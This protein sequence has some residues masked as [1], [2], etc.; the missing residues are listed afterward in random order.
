[1][2]AV[3]AVGMILKMSSRRG[4][5]DVTTV[6]ISPS[7]ALREGER[8]KPLLLDERERRELL[9]SLRT[10]P[11][12]VPL[13]DHLIDE[14]IAA[15]NDDEIL[16]TKTA[17][18]FYREFM[19]IGDNRS[20]KME[21]RDTRQK[22]RIEEG[23]NY[24]DVVIERLTY[25][26]CVVS[27]GDAT[28]SLPLSPWIEGF[29]IDK[30]L[31]GGPLGEDEIARRANYYNEKIRPTFEAASAR[32]TPG[33]HETM[34]MPQSAEQIATNVAA[35]MEHVAPTFIEMS[36]NYTPKPGERIPR[37]PLSEE[38]LELNKMSYMATH[39]PEVMPTYPAWDKYF[40]DTE[41][42]EKKYGS[43]PTP[44]PSRD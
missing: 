40:K 18:W 32:Y 37:K 38:D 5:F 30:I 19:E 35:Y 1:V 36:K 22:W 23:E 44:I 43:V 20:G 31:G 11:T 28:R 7:I 27:L 42:Y 2:I 34:P 33:P 39:H 21:N 41:E 6:P 9:E 12:P 17:Q 24:N 3:I 4:S 10:T 13:S 26:T 8:G 15:A 16:F 14:P 29:D 25:N